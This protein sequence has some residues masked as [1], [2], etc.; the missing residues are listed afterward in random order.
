MLKRGSFIFRH[1]YLKLRSFK[2]STDSH[3]SLRAWHIISGWYP[4]LIFNYL[5][6][7]SPAS[8]LAGLQL[9]VPRQ[10]NQ[11]TG[12]LRGIT[13]IRIVK[14]QSLILTCLNSILL[15]PTMKMPKQGHAQ[16]Q[17]KLNC[18]KESSA[19]GKWFSTVVWARKDQQTT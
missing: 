1:C 4:L 9:D 11:S 16:S 19:E 12:S 8:C 14:A 3:F 18:C 5:Y 15:H 17:L 2:N 10:S 6:S 13:A 7:A